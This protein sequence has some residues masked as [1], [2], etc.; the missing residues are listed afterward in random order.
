MAVQQQQEQQQAAAAAMGCIQHLPA[1]FA[2]LLTDAKLESRVQE[3]ASQSSERIRAE[4]A[5]ALT[6]LSQRQSDQGHTW[7][8]VVLFLSVSRRAQSLLPSL[9]SAAHGFVNDLISCSIS[10]STLCK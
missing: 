6:G 7:K 10:T 2:C 5:T 8:E 1:C 9:F 4:Q 3:R